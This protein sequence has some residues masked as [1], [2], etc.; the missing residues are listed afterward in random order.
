[1]SISI[2]DNRNPSPNTQECYT[3]NIFGNQINTIVTH[4]PSVVTHFISNILYKYRNS[5]NIIVGLDIEWRPSF[6]RIQNPPAII[7]LCID[8]KCLIFQFIYAPYMPQSLADFLNNPDF[9][10]VGVG[11]DGDV[12]KLDSFYDLNVYNAF[13]VRPLAVEK[14]GLSGLI[15]AGMKTMAD[16]VLDMEIDKPREITLSRWDD[17]Y[18]SYQQNISFGI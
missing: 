2:R 1:M 18:L 6:S 9:M 8:N 11:I 13:D 14:Y 12:R 4:T 7:Q 5:T 10:F 17:F 16:V 15:N 3:V